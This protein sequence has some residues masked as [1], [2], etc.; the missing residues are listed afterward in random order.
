[1][2][3]LV[4]FL[5]GLITVLLISLQ[6]V[7]A[8][9]ANLDLQAGEQVFLANCA[10]CHNGGKNTVVPLKTLQLGDLEK[11][12]KNTVDAIMYQVTNGN[13]AMPAFGDRLSEDDIQNVAGYVLNQATTNSWD[14]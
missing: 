7:F 2:K 10:A 14:N 8:Q 12:E 13:G 6:S 11:Y 1:M 9:D 5:S 4:S 3:F